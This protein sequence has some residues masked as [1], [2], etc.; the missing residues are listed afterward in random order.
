MSTHYHN[1]Y[2]EAKVESASPLQLV[3]L[4]YESA[5]AAVG[6]AREHLMNG[7]IQERSRAV[8]KV[9]HILMELSAALDHRAAREMSL[10]LARLYDYMI[11]RLREANYR[12]SEEPLVEVEGLLRTIGESWSKLATVETEAAHVPAVSG[13][14][15]HNAWIQP[16]EARSCYGSAYT[17]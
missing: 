16:A 12:Q 5:I 8:T 7:R 3:H 9:T 2:L 17:L 6:D 15:E 11:D 4:A 13:P 14:T 10:Q 1:A